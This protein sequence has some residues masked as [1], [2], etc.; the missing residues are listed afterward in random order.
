MSEYRIQFNRPSIAG[1]ELENVREAIEGGH[2]AG[3]G[4]FTRR[5][6]EMLESWTGT[7][8]ALLT[9]SCT[10]ALEMC[11]LLLRLEPGDEVIVPSFAFVTTAGAFALHGAKPIFADIHP[12]TLNLD[13]RTL[14][15]SVT[16][17]TKAIVALHYGGISC[18]MD[19]LQAISSEAGATLIE[20]NAHGLLAS[21]K[22]KPLGSFGRVATQSFHETKNFSCG[23]GGAL[24]LNDVDWIERAEIIREKG[25]DRSRFLRGQVDKY[26]W[27]DLGSSYLPSEI[28]A[29]FL[30]GQFQARETLQ[31]RRFEIW[32]NYQR[33]LSGWAA[34][35]GVELPTVPEHVEHACHLFYLILPSL[36]ARTRLIEH[37]GRSGILA[38]FHYQPLH[39]STMGQ[40]FGG[41][42]GQCPVTERVSDCLVRLPLFSDLTSEEQADIIDVVQSFQV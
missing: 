15:E 42:A 12:D 1:A 3:D 20:D 10:H 5:C 14:R 9:T 8:R 41:R 37:L 35:N 28:L 24:L 31:A 39:L 7:E 13:E 33:E 32:G 38:V 26:T 11:A 19:E 29:A 17:R 25:T 4:P 40:Q 6:C 27:V 23:E 30:Y 2:T 22:G 34:R 21:Y 16:S 36:D 18:E